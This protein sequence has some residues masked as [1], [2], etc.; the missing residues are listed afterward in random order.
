MTRTIA[1][2]GIIAIA[3]VASAHFGWLAYRSITLGEPLFPSFS[4]KAAAKKPA[5]V[6]HCIGRVVYIQFESAVVAKLRPDG[7]VWTCGGA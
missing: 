4:A 7:K 3:V 5:H 6:E 2:L 1:I